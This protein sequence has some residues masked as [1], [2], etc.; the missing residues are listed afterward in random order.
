[1]P[2]QP[3]ITF[4]AVLQSSGGTTTGF[5]VPDELV[6]RLGSRRPKVEV[7]VRGHTWRTSIASMGGRFLLGVSAEQRAA[8]GVGAGDELDVVARLD[9][10]ERTVTVPPDLQSALDAQPDALAFFAGLP[11]SQQRWFVEGV[12]GAKQPETRARRV[13][14]A[15]ERLASGRGQR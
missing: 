5:V 15:V 9:T 3:E 2:D 13:A 10:A 7:T 8:A 4:R 12:E 11:Y 14:A 1:M 6:A